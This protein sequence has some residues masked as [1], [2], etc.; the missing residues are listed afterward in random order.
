MSSLIV[1]GGDYARRGN[2]G[3]KVAEMLIGNGHVAYLDENGSMRD[4]NG[5]GRADG[6]RDSDFDLIPYVAV[7]RFT[8]TEDKDGILDAERSGMVSRQSD[9]YESVL[10]AARRLNSGEHKPES[11]TWTPIPQPPRMVPHTRETW[12]GDVWIRHIEDET[13][14]CKIVDLDDRGVIH[15]SGKHLSWAALRD[16]YFWSTSHKKSATWHRCETEVVGE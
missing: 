6:A 11:Y 10:L 12:P 9:C 8:L 2:P 14:T 3:R 15:A 4:T 1:K 5:Y 16:K 13:R 7:P